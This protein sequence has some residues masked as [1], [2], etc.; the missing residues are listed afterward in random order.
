V[1]QQMSDIVDGFSLNATI[2]SR[3]CSDESTR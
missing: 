2:T 3:M 1:L